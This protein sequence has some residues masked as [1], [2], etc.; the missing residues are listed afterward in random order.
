ASQRDIINPATEQ[1][2]VSSPVADNNQLEAA[3]LAARRAQKAWAELAV[4]ERGECLN[5][6]AAAVESHAAEIAELITLEVG[7]PIGLS[8]FEV[9]LVLKSCAYYSAQKL[10]PEILLDDDNVS[11]AIHHVALGVVAAILPWNA[12]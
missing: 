1:V 2:I 11:V 6:L 9:Q 12:P 7:R 8:H 4:E 5:K 10:E 3:V